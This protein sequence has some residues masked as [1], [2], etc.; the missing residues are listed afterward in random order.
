MQGLDKHVKACRVKVREP[1]GA[2]H[3]VR[4]GE[5]GQSAK[6]VG[7]RSEG[8]TWGPISCDGC[9]TRSKCKECRTKAPGGLKGVPHRATFGGPGQSAKNIGQGS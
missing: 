8:V 4:V 2:P 9:R 7:L 6:N 1:Q 3:H 5:P